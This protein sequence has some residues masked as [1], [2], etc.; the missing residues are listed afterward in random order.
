[1]EILRTLTWV[2]L[3]NTKYITFL[4]STALHI[5]NLLVGMNQSLSNFSIHCKTHYSVGLY[6]SEIA[7]SILQQW[8]YHYFHYIIHT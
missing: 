4:V 1:M 3:N 5:P 2:L 6:D 7:A 8:S